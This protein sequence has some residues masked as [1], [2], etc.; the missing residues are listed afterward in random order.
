MRRYWRHKQAERLDAD[1]VLREKERVLRP[2][3]IEHLDLQHNKLHGA[4]CL[5]Q[6]ARYAAQPRRWRGRWLPHAPR[7]TC[8]APRFCSLKS[9]SVAHNRLQHVSHLP[10]SLTA[11]DL[12]HNRISRVHGLSALAQLAELDLSGNPLHELDGL[13]HNPQLRTL[14]LQQCRLHRVTV[15]CEA[16]RSPRRAARLTP[17]AAPGRGWRT[18]A[19]WMRW[20]W[21]TMRLQTRMPSRSC[22]TTARCRRCRW[23][24]TRCM[25]GMTT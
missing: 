21:L 9:L 19:S 18:C 15:R 8:A 2:E 17:R 6:L 16:G 7:C 25:G 12:S 14:R 13:Q 24:G 3:V 22:G 5:A 1:E 20:T 4:N 10:F 23:W 11:L